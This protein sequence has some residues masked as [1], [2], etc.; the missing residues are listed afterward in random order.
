MMTEEDAAARLKENLNWYVRLLLGEETLPENP[1]AENLDFVQTGLTTRFASHW[2][3]PA[4]LFGHVG[5]RHFNNGKA[6]FSQDDIWREGAIVCMRDK[7]AHVWRDEFS[8]D[9]NGNF[10]SLVVHSEL[11][12]G[13][14]VRLMESKDLQTVEG[15]NQ[16]A[17]IQ[18]NEGTCSIDRKGTTK[19]YINL[20]E[21]NLVA[22]VEDV[23]GEVISVGAAAYAGVKVDGKHYFLQYTNHFRTHHDHGGH[24]LM[25]AIMSK[26]C[27]PKYEKIDGT[28][29]V[30]NG[31]N[32]HMLTRAPSVWAT[33]GLRAVFDCA[34]IASQPLGQPAMPDDSDEV[35]DLLNTTHK[36]L[37]LYLP[38]SANTLNARL[39]RCPEAY[40]WQNMKRTENAVL[41]TWFSGEERHYD[42]PDHSWTE[43]RGLILDHGAN[44]EGYGELEALIRSAAGEALAQGISHLTLFTSDHSPAFPMISNLASH[45]E[46]YRVNCSIPEPEQ[47]KERGIYIDPILA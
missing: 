17:R 40:S 43:T 15:M 27:V 10:A 41:G 1:F 19:A 20:L 6:P 34:E 28:L 30:I 3:N 47:T 32:E 14:T 4:Q 35:I 45:L 9:E 42:M 13:Y 23:R 38:Y 36:D 8:F 44:A 7:L 37:E 16:V 2:R 5:L 25:R 39:Q 26:V 29:F 22:V 11:A 33:G 24:K 31:G 18:V 12:D 21:D 46:P